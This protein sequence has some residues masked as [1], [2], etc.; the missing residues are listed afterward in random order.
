MRRQAAH[1]LRQVTEANGQ[2][3][4]VILLANKSDLLE[5][6]TASFRAVRAP[7]CARGTGAFRKVHVHVAAGATA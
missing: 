7:Q 4:P 2:P 3:I 6:G 1:S 5:G